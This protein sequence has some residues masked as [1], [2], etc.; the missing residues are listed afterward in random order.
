MIL[1]GYNYHKLISN[2]IPTHVSTID[3]IE[4]G[5]GYQTSNKNYFQCYSSYFMKMIKIMYYIIHILLNIKM[6]RIL[7]I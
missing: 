5:I 4:N 2:E 1:S 7:L 6:I 3:H